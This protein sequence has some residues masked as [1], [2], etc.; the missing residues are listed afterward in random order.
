MPTAFRSVSNQRVL[1]FVF[2]GSS[3][4]TLWSNSAMILIVTGRKSRRVL[5][6]E[7]IKSLS[8][9]WQSLMDSLNTGH[10]VGSESTALN[11]YLRSFLSETFYELLK[12]FHLPLPF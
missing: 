7:N 8:K 10:F 11:L 1:K 6:T 5:S 4:T 2:C 3:S 9:M 12:C